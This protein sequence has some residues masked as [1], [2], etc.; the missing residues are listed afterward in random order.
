MAPALAGSWTLIAWRRL[1]TSGNTTFPLGED[2][3][4]LLIYTHDGH[5]AVQLVAAGRPKIG[6][7][8]PLEGGD[9]TQ[10]ANAYSTCLA[11]FGTY[12]M[13]GDQVVHH[14]AESLFPD[15]SGQEQ[16]RLYTLTGKTLIL[17]TPPMHLPDGDVTNELERHRADPR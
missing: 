15:R 16:P 6:S 1:S 2:V 5:M 9:T 14:V 3:T 4:G 12:E 17:R 7:G 10:R 11:Y 13:E 8:D